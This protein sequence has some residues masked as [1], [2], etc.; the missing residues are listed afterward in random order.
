MQQR[1][2][3]KAKPLFLNH[4]G[5]IQVGVKRS[6]ET[7]DSVRYP[8]S[9]VVVCNCGSWKPGNMQ[10]TGCPVACNR[11]KT[12]NCHPLTSFLA[13]LF[14]CCIVFRYAFSAS[15]CSGVGAAWLSPLTA[16]RKSISLP[17]ASAF[18]WLNCCKR[19]FTICASSSF[20][21][22]PWNRSLMPLVFIVFFLL[23]GLQLYRLEVM[24]C[25]VL[26]VC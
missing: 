10:T 3:N 14:Q 26:D 2:F 16:F 12:K 4:L 9:P 5:C 23:A 25:Q 11:I 19:S 17:C 13:I 6:S 18:S 1:N 21:I 22:A 24:V 7:V 8:T 20:I 15:R